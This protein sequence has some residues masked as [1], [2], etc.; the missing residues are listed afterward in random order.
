MTKTKVAILY[1]GKSTE[2][3]V[4][5]RSAASIYEAINKDLF[6]VRL[7]YINKEGRFIYHTKEEIVQVSDAE[8]HLLHMMPSV[9]FMK[10]DK[11]LDIDVVFPVLHGNAGEDGNL[12]GMLEMLDVAYV[13]CNTRAS[14]V[15]M[16]KDM[17]KRLLTQAGIHVAPGFVFKHFEKD[18]IRFDAIK[19][20]LGLPMFIKPVNQGSSVGVSKVEDEAS[21]HEALNA[22][23]SLDTKVMVESGIIG[24]EIEVSVLG[25]ED[26][27]ISVPGEIV[28]NTGF[29]DYDSK[30][31]DA[32]GAELNIPAQ[33]SD[34]ELSSIQDV[35]GRT[36][37]ALDCEGL[38]RV[39]V[40]L[41]EDGRVIV[42]EVNTMP[43]FTSISMYPKLLEASG[44]S[45]TE[46][47]TQLIV[48][49]IA[50]YDVNSQLLRSI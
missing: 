22:A 3:E 44:V 38:S 21:F 20:T 12:Q 24:R 45:Y 41:T 1:G 28:S 19:E 11:V 26:L 4:S 13:G 29:Y 8:G 15:C 31:I 16:D 23:F 33:L 43:G 17:T 47:V 9:G 49:A 42:N 46:L 36:Y 32:D 50:R 2:H 25:N 30:Y 48:L 5:I 39:D 37:R 35:V 10:N 40:F 14:S 7:I 6:D 34:M 27:T 18:M